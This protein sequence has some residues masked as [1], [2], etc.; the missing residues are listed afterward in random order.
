MNKLDLNT[1][2]PQTLESSVAQVK[3]TGF[4]VDWR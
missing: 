4:N 2:F 1:A 3:K